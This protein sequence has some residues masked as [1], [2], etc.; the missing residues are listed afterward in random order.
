MAHLLAVA[1]AEITT[2]RDV[3]EDVMEDQEWEQ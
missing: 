3:A 1:A 2:L